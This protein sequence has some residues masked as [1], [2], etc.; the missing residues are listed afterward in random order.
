MNTPSD[1]LCELSQA[2]DEAGDHLLDAEDA[3][4]AAIEAR[5]E[6]GVLWDDAMATTRQVNG[7]A[8]AL[9]LEAAKYQVAVTTEY[10][11]RNKVGAV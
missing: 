6:G 4:I 3:V 7:L 8:S 10:N 11:A 5:R 2:T 1:E 9:S